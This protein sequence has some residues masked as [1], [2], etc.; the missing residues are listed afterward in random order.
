M[1]IHYVA[2]C[3]FEE[4]LTSQYPSLP[5]PSGIGAICLSPL[6]TQCFGPKTGCN[7]TLSSP[8]F[9]PVSMPDVGANDSKS[10]NSSA[11]NSGIEIC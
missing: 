10:C 1:L 4:A 3:N 5:F 9:V 6:D 7:G 11:V 8:L 2:A